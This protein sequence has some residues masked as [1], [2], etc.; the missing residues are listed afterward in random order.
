MWQDTLVTHCDALMERMLDAGFWILDIGRQLSFFIQHQASSIQYL[1][2]SG[3]NVRFQLFGS[4]LKTDI[5]L[6]ST[7]NVEL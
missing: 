5:I 1:S 4:K 3:I 7:W 6:N 2:N